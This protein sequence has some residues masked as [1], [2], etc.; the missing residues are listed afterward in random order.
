M[1]GTPIS[2]KP[3]RA[4]GREFAALLDLGV[5]LVRHRHPEGLH[6][7]DLL[8]EQRPLREIGA[9][10]RPAQHRHAA[11]AQRQNPDPP[12]IGHHALERLARRREDSEEPGAQTDALD[13][14]SAGHSVRGLHDLPI[15]VPAQRCLRGA[16][17]CVSA[18][19]TGTTNAG[20]ARGGNVHTRLIRPG[21]AG[22]FRPASAS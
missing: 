14:R 4:V 19:G 3:R 6:R 18:N 12:W 17:G 10:E 11:D 16:G 15:L 2:V 22:S 13:R 7:G 8:L 5:D 1:T 9:H 21:G 20:R